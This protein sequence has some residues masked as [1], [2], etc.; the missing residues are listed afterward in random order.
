MREVKAQACGFNERSGLLDVRAQHLAKCGMEQM[1]AGVVAA[2]GRT[3]IRVDDGIDLVSD[4]HRLAQDRLVGGDSLDGLGASAD[5]GD[6]RV[7]I[8]RVKPADITDLSAGIGV[9]GGVIE[10]DL[11]VFSGIGGGN[12][13]AVLND[14]EDFR[15]IDPELR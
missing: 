4:G 1:R 14:G 11:D 5:V 6:N 12:T 3:K 15:T 8:V 9:E 13:R 10:D 7:V 2:G